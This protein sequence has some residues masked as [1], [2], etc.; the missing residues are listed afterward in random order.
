ME[1]GQKFNVSMYSCDDK[2]KVMVGENTPAV[3]RHLKICS[4]FMEDDSP[5]YMDHDFPLLNSKMIPS[6]YMKL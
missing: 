5:N 4:F 3:G 6:G 2:N 1:F